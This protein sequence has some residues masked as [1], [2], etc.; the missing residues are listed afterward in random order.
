MAP[1]LKKGRFY[2]E[3]FDYAGDYSQ[4]EQLATAQADQ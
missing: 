4:H 1:I 3:S 2:V